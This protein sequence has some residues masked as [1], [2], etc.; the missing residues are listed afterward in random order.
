MRS[1]VDRFFDERNQFGVVVRGPAAPAAFNGV[2]CM[3]H[4][5]LVP[6]ER[7]KIYANRDLNSPIA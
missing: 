2:K 1:L 6:P 5:I 4:G 7:T 3:V